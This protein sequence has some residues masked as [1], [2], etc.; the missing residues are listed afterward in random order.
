MST[1]D[2]HDDQLRAEALERLRK[3]SEFWTHLVAYVLVNTFIVAIWFFAAGSGA[4][5]WSSTPG[6]SS[7]GRCRRIG[8]AARCSACPAA[9][10]AACSGS[11]GYVVGQGVILWV[12]YLLIARRF[13]RLGRGRTTSRPATG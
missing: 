9:S 13:L 11:V 10:A 1:L 6:T 4:S 7:A 8:S 5:G 12:W 2:T 3:R